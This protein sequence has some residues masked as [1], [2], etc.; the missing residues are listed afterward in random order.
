MNENFAELII[1]AKVT[2]CDFESVKFL[3]LSFKIGIKKNNHYL[4][5]SK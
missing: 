5:P 2:F 3:F 4:L 1:T